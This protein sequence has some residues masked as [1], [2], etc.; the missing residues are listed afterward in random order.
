MGVINYFS[1]DYQ[2]ARSKFLKASHVVGARVE[3]FKIPIAG[4]SGDPLFTDV[5]SFGEKTAKNFLVLQSGTHGVE[6]FAG[7][8]IQ[9]GLMREDFVANLKSNMGLVM[10][11]AINPFGFSHLRRFN[12]DNLDLNRNFVDHAGVYPKNDAYEDLADA[13]AP[14]TL[15]LLETGKSGLRFLWHGLK[16]GKESLKHAISWGQYSHPQG[17]FYGGQSE[18]WSNKTLREIVARYLADAERVIFIDF[19]TGLGPY[20]NAEVL[21]NEKEDSPSYKS[22]VKI[23]GDRVKATVSG[24]SVSIHVQGTLKLAVQKMLP[25]SEVI[26]VSLEFGT[27]PLMEV[28]RALRN[29]NWLHHRGGKNQPQ[30]NKIKEKLLRVFYP[31]EDDWK[32]KIWKQGK[33]VVEQAIPHMQ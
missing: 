1:N 6:G 28:F 3:S 11:H 8:G 9:T 14:K 2:E 26:A 12:E 15:S 10:I 23:W 30:A 19:H 16:N 31:N 5:A 25:N 22:A 24:K 7:S 18:A 17:L 20:G 21:L 4:P 29:E 33:E 32:L 27:V 13:I